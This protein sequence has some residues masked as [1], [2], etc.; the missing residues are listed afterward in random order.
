MNVTQFHEYAK[1]LLAP[2]EPLFLLVPGDKT[3]WKPTENSFTT[4]QLMHHMAV[5][6]RF[7]GKG[8]ERN[9][10]EGATSLRHIFLANRRTPGSSVANA[11]ALYRKTSEYFFNFFNGLNSPSLAASFPRKRESSEM[12][13][14]V[15]W[16]DKYLA[17][18]REDIYCVCFNELWRISTRRN[19]FTPAWADT[20]MAH[21]VICG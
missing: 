18:C 16:H 4:G 14:S 5:A 12:D 3:E 11:V 15:R 8:I 21:G 19:R 7:N 17:A 1:T 13:A 20:K 6:L 10:W 9:E 2:T